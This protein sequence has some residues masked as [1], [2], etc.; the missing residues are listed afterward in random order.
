[1]NWTLANFVWDADERGWT[2]I[3]FENH[4]I[5]GRSLRKSASHFSTCGAIFRIARLQVYMP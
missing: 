1:M 2:R 3:N 5:G 4:K